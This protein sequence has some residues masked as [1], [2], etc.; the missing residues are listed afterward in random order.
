MSDSVLRR[1]RY[2]PARDLV[3]GRISGR[4]DVKGAIE[5]SALPPEAK[6]I[7]RR[8]VKRTRLWLSEKVEVAHELIAHFADGIE[9]GANVETLIKKFGDERKAAK[10]IRRAKK[11]NRP[12]PWHIL[13]ALGW[14]IVALLT[15]YAFLA[16]RFVLGRPTP[17]VNYVAL[18][19]Q[20][21]LSMPEAERAWPLYRQAILQLGEREKKEAVD[22]LN[23]VFDARPGASD[24]EQVGPWLT[25]HQK[26]I[27][28]T[29]AGADKAIVG[30]ILGRHGSIDDPQLYPGLAQRMSNDEGLVV[31]VLL[32]HLSDIRVLA[33]AVTADARFA[34]HQSDAR[35]VMSDIEALLKLSEQM[36]RDSNVVVVDLVSLAIHAVALETIEGVLPDEKLKFD[37]A[38]LQKLAHLLSK[39]K[40][41]ADL[42]SFSGERM[43][44]L[45]VIQR[46]Y[47][48]DGAGDGHLTMQ[49]EKLLRYIGAINFGGA[50]GYSGA[51][52]DGLSWAARPALAEGRAQTAAKFEQMMDVADANLRRPLREANWREYDLTLE[53]VKNN[54]RRPVLGLAASLANCQTSTELSLGHRDGVVVGIALELYRRKHGEY[55]PSL[56]TLVPEYLPQIPADRITSEPVKYKLQNGKPLIYSVGADRDDDGGRPPP[57][58]NSWIA[59]AQIVHGVKAADGDWV[60]FPQVN[61]DDRPI[62][63]I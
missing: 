33:N 10:L 3:R 5:A 35:R 51:V 49:G 13:R 6:E 23:Q 15:I 52:H 30:F 61:K 24:W 12:L 44:V 50:S 31:S 43:M 18:M 32:P 26:V 8:V 63:A 29:R 56:Q 55:P 59:A 22:R 60:L 7:V 20:P 57:G 19:N 28:L 45:D 62:D 14:V 41:A 46:C 17:K 38:D 21:G 42:V 4:L 39:P 34:R 16:V 2:T 40:V 25:E 53:N 47:T 1:L 36:H 37:D 58:K 54:V 11:R 48:D 27:E 9:S